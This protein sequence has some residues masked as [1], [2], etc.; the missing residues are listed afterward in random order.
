MLEALERLDP[1][2]RDFWTWSRG[3]KKVR[4]PA[5]TNRERVEELIG[6]NVNRNDVDRKIIEDL[7]FSTWFINTLEGCEGAPKGRESLVLRFG[8]GCYSEWSSNSC[9][10]GLPVYPPTSERVLRWDVLAELMRI[11]LGT[12]DGESGI[13]TSHE[14]WSLVNDHPIT[15]DQPVGWLMYF[16]RRQGTVPPLPAPVRIEPVG[17]KGT[18]VILTPERLTASNA[19]HVEL[20]RQ[21]RRL[22][23]KA[24]LL[25]DP[26]PGPART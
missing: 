11:M 18:L 5:L 2:L 12:M 1:S 23:S 7:G 19:E 17:D 20:G 10:L 24:G 9:S 25:K 13:I 4:V 21:I 26:Y 15:T 14:H 16:S 22:L 6:R 3:R 8:C